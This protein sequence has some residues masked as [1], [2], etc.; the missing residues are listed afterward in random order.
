MVECE[1]L[2]MICF[3]DNLG[4]CYARRH[5]ARTSPDGVSYTPV[6][7]KLQLKDHLNG[8]CGVVKNVE[9]EEGKPRYLFL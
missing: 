9:E 1:K 5:E 3:H 8:G 7:T 4:T 6:M 2:M